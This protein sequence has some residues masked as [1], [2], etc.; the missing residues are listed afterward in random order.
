MCVCVCVVCMCVC[1]FVCVCVC[2]CV[3]VRVHVCVCLP[4]CVFLLI[5]YCG[6]NVSVIM[7]KDTI[8]THRSQVFVDFALIRVTD[9]MSNDESIRVIVRCRPL[10]ER[11]LNAHSQ[12]AP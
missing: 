4:F 5:L 2:M 1:V 11:E 12:C 8:E 9:N 6:A 10:N 7:G 3:R